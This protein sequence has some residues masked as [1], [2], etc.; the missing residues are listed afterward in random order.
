MEINEGHYCMKC[1]SH[2][3]ESCGINVESGKDGFG[4]NVICLKCNS[5]AQISHV[6]Q[7]AST[8]LE[9]QAKRMK[10]VSDASHP[11]ASVGQNVTVPIPDV[12]KGK[13]D[14][15]NIIAVVLNRSTQTS[16]HIPHL[17]LTFSTVVESSFNL[18]NQIKLYLTS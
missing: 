1:G 9:K 3:H 4:S 18:N 14:L 8:S 13:G 11:P 16:G 7:V 17:L 2:I 6:R 5:E 15:R 12:D 10:T